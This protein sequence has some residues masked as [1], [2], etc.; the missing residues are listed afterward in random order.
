MKMKG[1][2]LQELEDWDFKI[3]F[4]HGAVND[5]VVALSKVPEDKRHGVARKFLAASV[6]YCM[7]GYILYFLKRKGVDV[8]DIHTSSQIHIGKDESGSSAVKEIDLHI[9]VDIPEKDLNILESC[10]TILKNGCLISKSL[11]NGIAVNRSISLK[12]RGGTGQDH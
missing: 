2:E 7:T 6:T 10:R 9:T 3:S 1:V 12:N 8:S 4:D 5:I 11:E